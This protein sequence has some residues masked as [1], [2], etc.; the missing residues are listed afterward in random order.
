MYVTCQ[1]R[2][3]KEKAHGQE[4]EFSSCVSRGEVLSQQPLQLD[5]SARRARGSSRAA[6]LCCHWRELSQINL[7]THPCIRT[8][9]K[10]TRT[11]TQSPHTITDVILCAQRFSLADAG[12]ERAVTPIIFVLLIPGIWHLDEPIGRVEQV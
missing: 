9:P 11:S 8:N 3:G 7:H 1:E 5:S 12:S 10:P 2:E 4:V 6:E